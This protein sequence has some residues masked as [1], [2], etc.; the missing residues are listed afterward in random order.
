MVRTWEC[1]KKGDRWYYIE[2]MGT[3]FGRFKNSMQIR[4][5]LMVRRGRLAGA[6]PTMV[7]LTI[8]SYNSQSCVLYLFSSKYQVIM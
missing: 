6:L 1:H 2:R 7:A 8:F 3:L 4:A 5:A